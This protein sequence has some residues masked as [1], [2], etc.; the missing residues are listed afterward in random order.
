LVATAF[1]Q[2]MVCLVEGVSFRIAPGSVD[3]TR[4]L[5]VVDG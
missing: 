3:F 5:K 4:S 2:V 1:V